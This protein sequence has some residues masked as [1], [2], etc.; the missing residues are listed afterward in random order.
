MIINLYMYSDFIRLLNGGFD[1]PLLPLVFVS[2][3]L[4]ILF[5]QSG[6]DKI[7]DFNGNLQFL[8]A[9][10]KKTIFKNSVFFLLLSIIFLEILTACVF[11]VGLV[12]FVFSI[13]LTS[14]F[15]KL[16][17]ILSAI[18][19]CCLFLGQRIAKD[20]VGAANL[21]IY[22]ILTLLGFLFF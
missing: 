22:F 19:I 2:I 20:Y 7:L 1:D 3:F 5:T 21:T 18:T 8:T 14:Y 17:V 4:S 16:G 11:I 12:Q 15:F 6:L 9:H 13:T 10:F